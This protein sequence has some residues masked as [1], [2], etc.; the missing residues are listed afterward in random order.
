[1]TKNK[2]SSLK[3]QHWK[4]FF[5]LFWFFDLRRTIGSFFSYINLFFSLF[6]KRTKKSWNSDLK[7]NCPIIKNYFHTLFVEKYGIFVFYKRTKKRY[8]ISFQKV[9]NQL[10]Q[11]A[12]FSHW[13]NN[14]KRYPCILFHAI[15]GK[16]HCLFSVMFQQI[17][18]YSSNFLEMSFLKMV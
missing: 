15:A 10:F 8:K 13:Q 9:I 7:T 5:L 4:S 3:E 6:S 18:L 2:S 17:L 14:C 1:M 11:F 16:A 12:C